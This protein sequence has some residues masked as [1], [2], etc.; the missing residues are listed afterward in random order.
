[1]IRDQE[2]DQV[3][4]AFLA[5]EGR[6]M[7]RL[8]PTLDSAAARLATHVARRGSEPSASGRGGAFARLTGLCPLPSRGSFWWWD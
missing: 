7:A 6:E 8:A 5:D 3:I 2:L 4:Q 1:M